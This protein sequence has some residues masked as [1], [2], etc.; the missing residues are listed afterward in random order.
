M[1]KPSGI[2]VMFLELKHPLEP[3]K[4]VEAT[5]QFDTAGT[6]KVEFPIAAIGASAPGGGG[7]MM[8]D[9]GMM[10]MKGHH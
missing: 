7:T 6:V 9:G 8:Q 3:G 1:L 5:L 4:T 2:H 10:Q